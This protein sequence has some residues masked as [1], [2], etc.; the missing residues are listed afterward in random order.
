VQR[1]ANFAN[2]GFH[3]HP[4]AIIERNFKYVA[5]LVVFSSS[6][7]IHILYIEIRLN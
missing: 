1:L 5:V 2:A 4:E 6:N 7:A 3:V